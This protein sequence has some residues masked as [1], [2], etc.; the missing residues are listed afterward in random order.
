MKK[1]KLKGIVEIGLIGIIAV[2]LLLII[3]QTR[4]AIFTTFSFT[5][6][7]CSLTPSDKNCFCNSGEIREFNKND[8]QLYS[9]GP[10]PPGIG[11]P[12]PITPEPLPIAGQFCGPGEFQ[13]WSLSLQGL[14]REQAFD[15]IV[16]A[17]MVT[18]GSGGGFTGETVIHENDRWQYGE[19]AQHF[20]LKGRTM[21]PPADPL[22]TNLR[23]GVVADTG[24]S[25]FTWNELKCYGVLNGPRTNGMIL[26]GNDQWK[27]SWNNGNIQGAF[28]ATPNVFGYAG[29]CY[30][31]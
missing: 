9:C 18:T 15:R 21:L 17:C 2:A 1:H 24:L 10:I 22:N 13:I 19:T 27:V 8:D 11:E 29:I 30:T 5:T 12:Q 14:S 26:P 6:F 3:P 25:R 20:F 31:N 4:S 28:L 16:R 23:F 7:H